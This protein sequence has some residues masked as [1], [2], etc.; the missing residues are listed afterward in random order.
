[1]KLCNC[2]NSSKKDIVIDVFD[3]RSRWFFHLSAIIMNDD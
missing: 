2:L 1:M 3:G